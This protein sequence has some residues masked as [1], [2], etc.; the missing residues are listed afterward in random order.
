MNS[1]RYGIVK[2]EPRVR[3]A[4]SRRYRTVTPHI[5][6]YSLVE[7]RAINKTPA[8]TKQKLGT[9]MPTEVMS[10][11]RP[12][13]FLPEVA[14]SSSRETPRLL[15]SAPQED[16]ASYPHR[17]GLLASSLIPLVTVG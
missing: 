6:S 8:A 13:R 4:K 3:S 2:T 7:S 17:A 1:S 12:F 9:G 15:R 14:C 10:K 11:G 5:R 16:R